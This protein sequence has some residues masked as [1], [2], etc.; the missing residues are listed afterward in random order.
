MRKAKLGINLSA[1]SVSAPPGRQ[2]RRGKSTCPVLSSGELCP[3]KPK[4]EAGELLEENSCQHRAEVLQ[5]LSRQTRTGSSCVPGPQRHMDKCQGE[6]SERLPLGDLGTENPSSLGAACRPPAETMPWP[7]QISWQ[8]TSQRAEP[9]PGE[10]R[11]PFL[12]QTSVHKGSP[13]AG[14]GNLCGPSLS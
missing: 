1:R 11:L 7:S 10:G 8:G 12:L 3:Q 4:G 14:L 2:Q 6:S 5:E 13:Q 9:P